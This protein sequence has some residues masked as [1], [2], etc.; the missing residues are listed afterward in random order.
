MVKG[1]ELRNLKFMNLNMYMLRDE[2]PSCRVSFEKVID[3]QANLNFIAM[4]Y[5]ECYETKYNELLIYDIEEMEIVECI[6]INPN[7]A[8]MNYLY[9]D[10]S[11][12]N[13]FKVARNSE[14][15]DRT[16]EMEGMKKVPANFVVQ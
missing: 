15:I 1:G 5:Q 9:V 6:D 14:L 10:D 8:N 11:G 2:I 4:A 12:F 7:Q 13:C 16:S 3:L